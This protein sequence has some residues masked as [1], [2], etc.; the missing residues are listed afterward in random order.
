MERFMKTVR[1]VRL[2][3]LD[4]VCVCLVRFIGTRNFFSSFTNEAGVY[5][6]EQQGAV[7]SWMPT[8]SKQE[9]EAKRCSG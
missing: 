7:L 9:E 1:T 8:A 2:D 5:T 3:C 4:S 6:P